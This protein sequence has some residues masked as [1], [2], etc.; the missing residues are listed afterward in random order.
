MLLRMVF[1][2]TPGAIGLQNVALPLEVTLNDDVR[3]LLYE[4]EDGRLRIAVHRSVDASDLDLVLEGSGWFEETPEGQRKPLPRLRLRSGM[5][6]ERFVADDFVSALTFLTDVPLS[7]SRPQTE[8]VFIA[9]TDDEAELLQRFGTDQPFWE[10]SAQIRSRTFTAVVDSD[11]IQ[12]LLSRAPGLRLYADAM[13]LPLAVAQFRE[14]WRVLESAFAL[15]DKDLVDRLASYPPAK[16]LGFEQNEL[17]ALRT[18]RGR[19][20]HAQSSAEAGKQELVDVEQACT[21]FLPRLKTLV[22]R[23]ILTKKSWGYPSTGVDELTP[24]QAF[25]RADG[26]LVYVQRPQRLQAEG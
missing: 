19:G 10:T 2:A 7:L 4:H 13:K 16:Q 23:V 15:S 24:V 14:L 8:D 20:S 1:I 9:E 6:V 17:E 18:L 5:P 26:T 25:T 12:L 21:R 11:A 22:E 3:V